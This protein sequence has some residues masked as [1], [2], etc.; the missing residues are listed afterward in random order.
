MGWLKNLFHRRAY[1]DELAESIREHLEEKTEDLMEAGLS[2]EE[3]MQRARREFGNVTL[4]EERSREV[5][6]WPRLESAWRDGKHAVRQLR[7][8]SGFTVTVVLTLALS[9]G[10]NTAI[11][12]LVNALLLKSLPYPQP[13]R[14]GT[15]FARTTGSESSDARRNIDGEQWELLQHDVPSLTAAISALNTSGVNLESGSHAQ[16]VHEG[17]VSAHYFDVLALHPFAGRNFSEEEDRPHGPRAAILSYALWRAAFDKDR[18]AIG[19]TVLLK[20]APYTIVGVLPESASTPLNA[21]LYTALQ[22]SRE[23][24]GQATNFQAILRLH[25]GAT[26]EQAN[27]EINRAL[28]LSVRAQRLVKTGARITYYSVPMQKGQTDTL[29]PQVLA[30]MVAA[31]LILLIA[32]ANLAG[33]TLVRMLRRTG[34]IATRLALGASRWQIQRQLWIENLLLAL[35]GGT[36]AIAV[37]FVALR[38]LLLLLPDHFL[39]V[40]N[41]PLDNSVLGFTLSVSLLT[42]MLF[43]MLPALTTRKVD[44]RSSMANRGV[45]GAGSIRLRQALIAGE[46]ALT[47]VLLAAAGLLIRTLIHLETMPPGFNPNGVITAKASLD[48]VRYQDPGAFRKLLNESLAAMREIPG[49]RNAAVGLTVPYERAPLNSVTLTGGKE[50]GREVTTNDVYVTPGYFETLRIPVLA[51]RAFTD[52]DDPNAQPVVIV[53][54][55]FAR[56]FFHELN[57]VGQFL[58]RNNKNLLI[59]GVMADT[60]LSSAARLNS[61][62]APLTKEEAI[63]V[64]AAQFAD[65]KSLSLLNTWFQ[66]SWVIRANGPVKDLI[67]QMQR[68]LASADPN[69]PFS[70]FYSMEDLMAGTL[71]M[72]RIEVALLAAMASLALLL[73]SVG[74]FALVA[75]IVAQRTREIGI[76]IALGATVQKAMIHIGGSGIRAS[77]LGLILGLILCTAALRAMRSVLYGVGVYDLPTILVVVSTLSAVTLLATTIPSLRIARIDPVKTLREE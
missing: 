56:K 45:I 15:I 73:S 57:P 23:G 65:G 35:V 1:Y 60:V 54:Q 18:D 25:N 26:W 62:T 32:C 4:I 50:S 12:S 46:V 17:R 70:G 21:D 58:K 28:T 66:P 20:G 41:V 3:A 59:V 51:G 76:R 74:I 19:E 67:G 6:Q 64:P 71:A 43:G 27:G 38:G 5:W 49:V 7:H 31:G 9:I 61:G 13:D 40:A 33:L 48:D 2:R 39:P 29:R 8:N 75:N 42:S 30:L 37:G 11:F 77:A 68:A 14:L 24:E 55:T 36:A 63:Y 53:N 34:E 44:L 47:V 72:Q 16:Y 69:L 52:A 22:P 10:A